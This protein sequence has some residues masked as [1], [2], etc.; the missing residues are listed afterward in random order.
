MA[1]DLE[2]RVAKLERTAKR[3]GLAVVALAV[4]CV[5]LGA[6]QVG[7][8]EATFD[9]VRASQFVIQDVDGK[10]S[11]LLGFYDSG[12]GLE[13]SL[14]LKGKDQEGFIATAGKNFIFVVKKD[15]TTS[16]IE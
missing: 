13:N 2:A 14:V 8:K 10:P 3:R 1:A 7:R 16:R 15:G 12:N 5:G 4:L 11:G 6:A 9:V